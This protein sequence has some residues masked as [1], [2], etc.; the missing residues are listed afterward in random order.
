MGDTLL[1][2]KSFRIMFEEEGEGVDLCFGG[3]IRETVEE[4]EGSAFCLLK[5][6][7]KDLG[8]RFGLWHS[9]VKG[10]GRVFVKRKG[11]VRK[12]KGNGG[13]KRK[14]L[15]FVCQRKEKGWIFVLEEGEGKQRRKE[16]GSAFCLSKVEIGDLGSRFGLWHS[17]VKGNG[18]VSKE[19]GNG[20]GKR[21]GLHFVCQRW[22]SGIWGAGL[23]FGIAS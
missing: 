14:G 3:R 11:R 7:I 6:E 19:K 4:R 2:V 8:S 13:G 12:E 1:L 15:H 18:R 9:I 22:R 17:I 16:K 20:G 23:A 21:K 10:K 5:V